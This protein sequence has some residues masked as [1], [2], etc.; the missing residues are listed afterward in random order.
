MEELTT[1]EIKDA[2]KSKIHYLISN[3]DMYKTLC[4]YEGLN[5]YSMY[6][7]NFGVAGM[8]K[9]ASISNLEINFFLDNVIAKIILDNFDTK[10]L[11]KSSGKNITVNDQKFENVFLQHEIDLTD[12]RICDIENYL[13][14][15]VIEKNDE[16]INISIE[17]PIYN[18]HYSE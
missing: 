2:I 16:H 9:S 7:F 1:E 18:L 6:K 12:L 15:L 17:L 8:A 11:K 14:D 5:N 10:D 13:D 3:N 4:G